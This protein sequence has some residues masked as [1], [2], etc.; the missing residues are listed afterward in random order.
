M[1]VFWSWQSD[2]P[3]KIGRHFVRDVLEAAI[4][5][6]KE[7]P[8][9]EEAE[10]REARSELHL[11]Q[12]RKGI[13]GSP[14][15]ARIILEKIEQSTVFVADVTP[16]G[17]VQTSPTGERAKKLINGNVAIELGYAL[18]ALSDRAILMVLNEHYGGRPDLPFDLQSKAGPIIYNLPPEAAKNEILKAAQ[19]LKKQLKEALGLCIASHVEHIR[20]Q[21]PFPRAE[22]GEASAR[23]RAPDEPLGIQWTCLGIGSGQP[24]FLAQGPALWLRLMPISNP[25]R[26]W[27]SN[28]LC[29]KAMHPF[30]LWPFTQGLSLHGIRAGDGFGQYMLLPTK[31]NLTHSVAFAFETGEVWSVDTALLIRKNVLPFL[32]PYFAARFEDYATYL[33]SLG[34]EPP[35]DWICGLS[36]IKDF[37]LKVPVREGHVWPWDDP[38]CLV[39]EI[40]KEGNYDGKQTATSALLPFFELIFDKCGLPRPDHLPR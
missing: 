17:A 5:E 33:S 39:P 11:D 26:T 6:L 8:E 29:Q 28:M 30:K 21:T 38:Q 9:I 18:H 32:E 27:S 12:D 10:E 15:L 13:P 24:V 14:D 35:Y 4:K 2:S 25:G 34:M 37:R 1:K 40:I 22:A 31:E 36:G 3:G 23:F 16:I 19:G 20:Q 7:M